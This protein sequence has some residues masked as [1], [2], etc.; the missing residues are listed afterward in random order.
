M[1]CTVRGPHDGS[2]EMD[3]HQEVQIYE[4]GFVQAPGE[5]FVSLRKRIENFCVSYTTRPILRRDAMGRTPNNTV[6]AKVIF[7]TVIR[8]LSLAVRA[9]MWLK[10]IGLSIDTHLIKYY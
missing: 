2:H 8:I 1:P 6:T 9:C 7:D 3:Q 5:S 10:Y 4:G